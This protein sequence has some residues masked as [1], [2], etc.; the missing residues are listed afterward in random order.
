MFV[1]GQSHNNAIANA[2]DEL[3]GVLMR[4]GDFVHVVFP[5]RRLRGSFRRLVPNTLPYGRRGTCQQRRA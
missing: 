1:V 2:T 5:E 4:A 3:K